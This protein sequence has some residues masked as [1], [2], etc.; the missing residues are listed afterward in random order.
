VAADEQSPDKIFDREWAVALLAKVVERLRAECAEAGHA[1]HF[2]ELKIFLTAEKGAMPHASAAAA[3]GMNEGAV[4]VAVHRLRVRY[5]ALLREE[6]AQT[7]SD[8]TQ[9]DEELRALFAACA[10]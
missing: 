7:L 10:A 3:L 4:R 5:R 8:S 6:I 2:D 9:V 1:Q